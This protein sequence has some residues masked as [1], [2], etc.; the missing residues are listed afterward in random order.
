MAKKKKKIKKFL[1]GAALGIA[2]ILG[3]GKAI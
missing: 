2:G 1:K 3:A